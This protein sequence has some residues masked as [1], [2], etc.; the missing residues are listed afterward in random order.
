MNTWPRGCQRGTRFKPGP[1]DD[2]P[3]ARPAYPIRGIGSPGRPFGRRPSPGQRL[4]IVHV[5]QNEKRGSLP[6]GRQPPTP[7]RERDR[8]MTTWMDSL[9]T[10]PSCGRCSSREPRRI[11]GHPQWLPR[12][13][14]RAGAFAAVAICRDGQANTR[15]AQFKAWKADPSGQATT[16]DSMAGAIVILIR[17]MVPGS[18]DRLARHRPTAG[19]ERRPGLRRG[20]PGAKWPPG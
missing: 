5:C 18:P 4:K 10:M 8:T 12:P 11:D 16:L 7:R 2:R 15:D 17:D 9:G 6:E 3:P 19:S 1:S 14:G 13:Q 20:C